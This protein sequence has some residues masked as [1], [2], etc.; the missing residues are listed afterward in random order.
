MYY[1]LH[2]TVQHNKS[3]VLFTLKLSSSDEKLK[4]K[5]KSRISFLKF[6]HRASLYLVVP[7]SHVVFTLKSIYLYLLTV[8]Q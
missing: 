8:A 5:K 2:T 1:A 7:K 6:I 3:Y 4:S